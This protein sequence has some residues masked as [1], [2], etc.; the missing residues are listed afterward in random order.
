MNVLSVQ[1]DE[2]AFDHHPRGSQVVCQFLPFAIAD[3]A[4]NMACDE[5]LLEAAASGTPNLRFYGW[6][7]ATVSLGYFQKEELRRAD[8]ALASLPYVRRP[9]GGATLVHH[10][11]LTYALALP[12]GA[13]W[14]TERSWLLKMHEIVCGGLRRFGIRSSLESTSRPQPAEPLCFHHFTSGDVVIGPHKIV[15]SAQRRQRGGLL[16]HGA[17]LLE[18]SIHALSLPGLLELTGRR[19]AVDE[20]CAAVAAEFTEETGWLLKETSLTPAQSERTREL[21]HAKYSQDRWNR[22]R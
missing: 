19:L 14:Q 4:H 17:I 3:G 12:R 11:E 13:P 8:S 5:V 18:K 16:Q 20:V 1:K 10:H 2:S 7:E 9:T 22:K 6:S 21:A 15:G